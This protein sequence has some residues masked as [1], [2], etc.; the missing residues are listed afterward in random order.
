MGGLVFLVV[1]ALG[2]I[3]ASQNNAPATGAPE[4][5]V[6]HTEGGASGTPE[7]VV[8]HT[9]GGAS[10]TP[11]AGGS[12][13]VDA[14]W[15]YSTDT[16]AVSHEVVKAACVESANAVSIGTW[17]E[18]YATLCLRSGHSDA[19][20][21]LNDDRGQF[22]CGVEGCSLKA[23][24]DDRPVQRFSASDEAADFSDHTL[25]VKPQG[26]LVAV[27]KHS[28]S[29]VFGVQTFESGGEQELRFPVAGLVWDEE[30]SGRRRHG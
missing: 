9:E 8:V 6:V 2:L 30:G 5:V 1:L 17:G 16:Q 27:L 12:S 26:R 21:Q 28:T 13:D 29:V 11:N 7:S 10:G 4:T 14:Q 25:F 22:V 18:T 24:F 19:I 23:R 20:I 3:V 15:R